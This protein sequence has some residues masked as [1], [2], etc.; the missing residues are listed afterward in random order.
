M[1]TLDELGP[2]GQK[3]SDEATALNDVTEIFKTKVMEM[4]AGIEDPDEDRELRASVCSV[5]DASALWTTQSMNSRSGRPA[6]HLKGT[7]R[8]L[9]LGRH[10]LSVPTVKTTGWCIDARVPLDCATGTCMVSLWSL[11]DGM[12]P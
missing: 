3:L 1:K 8:A 10:E 6:W 7:A 9:V 4:E 12:P 5:L 11:P 2:R